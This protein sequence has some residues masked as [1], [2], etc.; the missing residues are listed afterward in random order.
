MGI[1]LTEQDGAMR[2]N[3]QV[4][5]QKSFL[6]NFLLYAKAFWYLNRNKEII[7]LVLRST[8]TTNNNNNNNNNFIKPFSN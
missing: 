2:T 6:H 7:E 4:R 8:I 3:A 5:R 1:N